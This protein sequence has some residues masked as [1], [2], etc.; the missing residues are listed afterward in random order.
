MRAVDVAV[1][2]MAL[3]T[4]PAKPPEAQR[5]LV[6]AVDEPDAAML[7][8]CAISQQRA[9]LVASLWPPPTR[10]CVT[11]PVFIE[12]PAPATFGML[13]R[14]DWP[15]EPHLDARTLQTRLKQAFPAI[16]PETAPADVEAA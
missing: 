13:F 12:L 7:D 10:Q 4:S 14:V 16:E 11:P 9:A 3:R 8:R 2:A 6:P 1:T 15:A 5:P